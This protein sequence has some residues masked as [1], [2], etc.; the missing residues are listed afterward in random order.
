MG[1][2]IGTEKKH[3]S[4]EEMFGQVSAWQPNGY[5]LKSFCA[6]RKY[7]CVHFLCGCV[8]SVELIKLVEIVYPYNNRY[9]SLT[10]LTNSAIPTNL[11]LYIT[12]REE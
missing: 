4:K 9:L 3:L 7:R 8:K 10:N 11:T 6:K 1:S 12:H 2:K 5:T